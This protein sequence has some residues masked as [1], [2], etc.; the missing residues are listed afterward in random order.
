MLC[1]LLGFQS[2]L[3]NHPGGG[4]L[5]FLFAK[6]AEATQAKQCALQEDQ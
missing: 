1:V 5:S 3:H 2:N 4:Y 6:A